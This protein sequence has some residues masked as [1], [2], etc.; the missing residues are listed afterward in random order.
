[1]GELIVNSWMSLDGVI[2]APGLPDEDPSDGFTNGG[3]VQPHFEASMGHA[4]AD[5]L[6]S[7]DAFLFGRITFD[8]LAAYWPTVTDQVPDAP[9]AAI[10]NPAWKY[11]AST[12]LDEPLGWD[13]ATLLGSD[14]PAAVA[15]LKDNHRRLVVIG[16]AHLVRTLMAHRLVDTYH[17]WTF[18]VLLGP[19]KKLFGDDPTAPRQLTLVDAETSPTGVI[20]SNYRVGTP[21]SSRSDAG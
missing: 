20:M 1:M 11:V 19:G 4:L 13:H 15:R 9:I 14:V 2:Q 21:V 5:L 16:S 6:G 7:A 10:L 17:L 3:W 18:P 12:T 8:I